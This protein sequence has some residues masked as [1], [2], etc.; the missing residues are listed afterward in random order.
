[1]LLTPGNQRAKNLE[2]FE[3][4]TFCKLKKLKNKKKIGKSQI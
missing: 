3:M 1:M 2:G 4:S